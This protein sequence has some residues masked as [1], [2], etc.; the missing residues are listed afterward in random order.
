MKRKG[1]KQENELKK[2]KNLSTNSNFAKKDNVLK[3]LFGIKTKLILSFLITVCFII[4]LGVVSYLKSSKDIINNYVNSGKIS[5]EMM[6]EYVELGMNTVETKSIQIDSDEVLK[7]YY[8]GAYKHNP[9]EESNRYNEIK[10]SIMASAVA[11]Q[12]VKDITIIS[13]YGKGIYSGSTLENTV[14]TGF[15]DSSE[16]AFFENSGETTV[17]VGNHP[18]LDESISTSQNKYCFSMIRK[19]NSGGKNK[20]GYIIIDIKKEFVDNILAKADFGDGSITGIITSDGREI[21]YGNK[22]E[23][24]AFSKESFF[25][26]SL[27]SDKKDGYQYVTYQGK[28][29]LF[30][31]SSIGNSKATICFLIPKEGI[32]KQADSVKNTTIWI[33]LITSI[34]AVLIGTLLASGIGKTIHKINGVLHQVSE[35]NLTTEILVKRK[36]EFSVLS[37]S[38]NNMIESMK[39]LLAQ[40]TGV[41]SMVT[42][43]ATDVNSESEILLK[44]TE[45]I[46]RVIYSIEQSMSQQAEDAQNC[47][48][49]M[50]KLAKEI[51]LVSTNANEI[52]NIAF[53]TKDVVGK[54][55]TILK[56]LNKKAQNTSEITLTVIDNIENLA[57]DLLSIIEIIET[58][59]DIEEKTNLL[60]LNASIEA[61]RAGN[62]GKGFAVVADEIR[63]LAEQSSIS[64][65]HISDIIDVIQKQTTLT[66]TSAKQAEEIVGTQSSALKDTVCVFDDINEHIENLSDKL[67]DITNGMHYMEQAKDSTLESIESISATSEETA[68]ASSELNRSVQGQLDAVQCLNQAAN[69]LNKSSKDLK[70]AISKFKI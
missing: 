63:K 23:N 59:R 65:G 22:D 55:K 39:Y 43:T 14:Y 20:T 44:T 70:T 6:A 53:N 40:I 35:G 1:V 25:Q 17:W 48:M 60:S 66:V 64:V 30:L 58:I 11:D 52:E 31:Y 32:M 26:N 45:D 9:L 10:K 5:L 34:I 67:N 47:L 29:Y 41:S 42:N 13:E 33:V 12:I 18:Y 46:S 62:A 36:D 50:E 27:K 37:K 69:G 2:Y 61:A 56:D 16:K 28:E 51:N 4:I 57:S 15:L 68:A 24:F 19:L 7:K 38:I 3:K 49:L 21:V 8:I 54:G